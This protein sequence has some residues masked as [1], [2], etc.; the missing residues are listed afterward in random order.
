VLKGL[1]KFARL[2]LYAFLLLMVALPF[3]SLGSYN[4]A[5]LSDRS[6]AFLLTNRLTAAIFVGATYAAYTMIGSFL[7]ASIRSP[8]ER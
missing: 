6:A 8:L 3:L 5:S 7:I 4:E 1:S 2:G